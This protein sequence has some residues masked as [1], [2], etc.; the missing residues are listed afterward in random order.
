MPAKYTATYK[1]G[2]VSGTTFGTAEGSVLPTMSG[3]DDNWYLYYTFDSTSYYYIATAKIYGTRRSTAPSGDYIWGGVGT[4]V[5][6]YKFIAGS[7]VFQSEKIMTATAVD[8]FKF[9]VGSISN[10][11]EDIHNDKEILI[12]GYTAFNKLDPNPFPPLLGWKRVSK[13]PL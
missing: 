7:W 9:L 8:G 10:R 12:T 4:A 2:F 5:R 3:Y 6:E 13:L 11:F 1:T